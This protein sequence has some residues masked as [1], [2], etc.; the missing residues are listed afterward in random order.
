MN[1]TRKDGLT[2]WEVLGC[3]GFVAGGYVF[4]VL[5]LVIGNALFN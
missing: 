1:R 2:V 5:A 3:F 4:V